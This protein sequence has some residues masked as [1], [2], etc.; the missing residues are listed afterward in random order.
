MATQNPYELDLD[1]NA[2]NYVALSPLSFIRRTAAVY[3]DRT[4]VIHG[5]LTAHVATRPTNA[6]FGWPR[7][8]GG[9]VSESA[10]PWR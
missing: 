1:K 6:A 8:S 7:R 3:P 9:A 10:T 5:D 4:A 2:A